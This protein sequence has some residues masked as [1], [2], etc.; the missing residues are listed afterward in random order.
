MPS[1]SQRVC[2]R[3]RTPEARHPTRSQSSASGRARARAYGHRVATGRANTTVLTL[4]EILIIVVSE[5]LAVLLVQ[6]ALHVCKVGARRASERARRGGV[7][8]EHRRRR[9]KRT[10]LRSILARIIWSVV[11]FIQS[12]TSSSLFAAQ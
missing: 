2:S 1:Q 5:E 10:L 7:A 12:S 11:T 8:R 4:R 6:H 3:A 9:T